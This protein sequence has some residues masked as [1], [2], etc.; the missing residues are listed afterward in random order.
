MP[1]NRWQIGTLYPEGGLNNINWSQPGGPGTQ[2]FPQQQVGVDYISIDPFNEL[3]GIMSVGCGHFI[4]TPLIQR[5]YD[6][7]TG[8]SVALCTCPLCGYIQE[9][10][11]PFEAALDTV[12]I[13]QLII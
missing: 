3:T 8:E 5:E 1:A 12:A 2:V 7:D 11:E 6:Y 13:P 4:N 10:I 9:A